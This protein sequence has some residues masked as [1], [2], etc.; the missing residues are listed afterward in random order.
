[1]EA[2]M[3]CRQTALRL[4]GGS[5]RRRVEMRLQEKEKRLRLADIQKM[6]HISSITAAL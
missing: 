5:T 3:G 4:N 2:I 1:M 6:A